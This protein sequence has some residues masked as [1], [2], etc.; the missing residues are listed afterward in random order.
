[1][2]INPVQLELFSELTNPQV[3]TE[4]IKYIGSK[5]RLLPH[6]IDIS[7]RV[8]AR[9]VFDGFSGTTRVAQAFAQLGCDVVASDVAKWSEV[10]ATCYL[11]KTRGEHISEIL[12]ELNN[13]KPF[14]GWFTENYGGESNSPMTDGFKR[15]WQK[16]NTRKLDAI[17]ERISELDLPVEVEAT[18]LTSL[19]LALDQV[20]STLGH[21]ASYLRH[22]SPRS[23]NEIILQEPLYVPTP[24][25]HRVEQGDVFN[26][27][28]KIPEVDLAYFDPPYGSNNDKMPPSRVRYSSYYHI[29]T[30]VCLND[31]PKL[32]GKARRR[33]DSRD[34]VATSVF[35]E[36]RRGASGKFLALEAIEC[37]LRKVPAR[38]VLLSYSSGGRATSNELV[39]VLQSV[40]E[41]EQVVEIEYKKNVMSG[42]RWT[43]EWIRP[44]EGK[45]IEYLYLMRKS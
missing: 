6:I 3:R 5:L 35:E 40:G 31:K 38:H 13:A 28:E 11:R 23:F 19:I 36:Y 45:N 8:N 25:D 2:S 22:W 10:F 37:L 21:F 12:E 41:I 33:E 14:D 32:F 7:K 24:G 15:P 27:I 16:H 17:R 39:D 44:K 43:N 42:M 20:D 30:T 1:M 26:V 4:G 9:T 18:M 29:W 34:S